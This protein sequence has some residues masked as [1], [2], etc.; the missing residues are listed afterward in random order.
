VW[1]SGKAA[2]FGIA[3]RRFESCH[4]SQLYKIQI[5]KTSFLGKLGV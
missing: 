5:F 2:V 1:P 4:P 3:M